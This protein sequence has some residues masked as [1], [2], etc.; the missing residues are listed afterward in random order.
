MMENKKFWEIETPEVVNIGK[1]KSIEY[2]KQAG[3]LRFMMQYITRHGQERYK[4]I[5][6]ATHRIKASPEAVAMLRDALGL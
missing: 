4:S 1:N 3:V 5:V 6:F 2:Y